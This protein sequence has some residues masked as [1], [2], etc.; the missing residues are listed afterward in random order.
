MRFHALRYSPVMD[1]VRFRGNGAGGRRI[2]VLAPWLA[3]CVAAIALQGCSFLPGIFRGQEARLPPPARGYDAPSTVLVRKGD[4]LYGLSRRYGIS[5]QEIIQANDLDAPYVIYVGETLKLPPP[6]TYVVQRGDTLYSISGRVGSSVQRIARMN[7]LSPPYHLTEGQRLRVRGD[8]DEAA[9]AAR[10]VRP[11]DEGRNRP[12]ARDVAVPAPP[13]RSERL[14]LIPVQGRVV[15]TF[16]PKN[17]GLRNDGVNIAAPRGTK[18]VASENGVVAYAG[19][20]IAGFGNL[21]LLKHEDDWI[22]AYAHADETLV[23][24]GQMVRRGDV[25]ARVGSSGS[26]STPQLHFQLRHRRKPVD[27]KPYLN[28]ALASAE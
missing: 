1:R 11:V 21:V 4:T 9:V 25:I 28:G 13:P 3:I 18:I 16:G 26:V 14:F 22:S 24:R 6:S 20:E 2:S 8:S 23:Q 5:L 15:S 17:G 12:G 10:A 19:D 7:D 27:P